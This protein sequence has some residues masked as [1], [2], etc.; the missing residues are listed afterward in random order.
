MADIPWVAF[1]GTTAH[2][3]LLLLPPADGTPRYGV[4]IEL[5]PAPPPDLAAAL[6][7]RGFRPA[8][9][10]NAD[11]L[12][13]NVRTT[14]AAAVAALRRLPGAGAAAVDMRRPEN[15]VDLRRAARPA[16]RPG[17]PDGRVNWLAFP[18]TTAHPR[19][20]LLPPADGAA[21]SG[22]AIGSRRRPA[23]RARRRRHRRR[24]CRSPRRLAQGGVP[25]R[26]DPALVC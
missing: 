3:R 14:L 22:I 26:R 6:A 2:P 15:L 4:L 16:R 19:L 23:A 12:R 5:G 8:V 11:V 10:G 21:R 20:M 18:G 1:P 24:V 13:S 7:A 17:A 25:A 9:R